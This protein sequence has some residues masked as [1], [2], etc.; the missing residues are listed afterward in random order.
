MY[1]YALITYREVLSPKL[2]LGIGASKTT[3]SCASSPA[4]PVRRSGDSP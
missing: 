3:P 2:L 4:P 1:V